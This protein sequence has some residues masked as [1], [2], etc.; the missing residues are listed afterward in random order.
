MNFAKRLDNFT[1]YAF[2]VTIDTKGKG[3]MEN[4]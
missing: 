3:G 2:K 4:E 1:A